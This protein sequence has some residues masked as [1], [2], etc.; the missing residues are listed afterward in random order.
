MSFIEPTPQH[1][2][3]EALG[4]ILALAP[5]ERP[6]GRDQ[7]TAFLEYLKTCRLNW[8]FWRFRRQ[9][10]VTAH[11][12]VLNLPG[13]TALFMFPSPEASGVLREDQYLIVSEVVKRLADKHLYF[14][15]ALVEPETPAKRDV[16]EHAGFKRL[17]RLIYTQR[18]V[19]FAA[20]RNRSPANLAW[21]IYS[22]ATH[23]DFAHILRATYEDS[24]DCPELSDLRPIE[25]VI[26]AHRAAGEFDPELWEIARF[27]E[28]AASCLL[29]APHVQGAMMEIVYLGV[30]RAWRRKGIGAAL[31]ERALWHCRERGIGALTAVVDERN[32]P[33]R[34]LYA[35]FG[36]KPT[37]SR[38]AY[39]LIPSR[40][41]DF[42]E[43]ESESTV[44]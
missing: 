28:Q 39:L 4:R 22:E 9:E 30:A 10:A 20:S 44:I 42:R 11:L 21:T 12:L 8:T 16:L 31:I 2:W 29:L 13:Q 5:S 32:L 24:A 3:H 23:A 27:N 37:A 17:T 26:A 34:Q 6:A 36:F 19:S 15:Q 43:K 40:S 41:C 33:A 14:Y 25:A 35:R 7:I 1:D 18:S 38:E